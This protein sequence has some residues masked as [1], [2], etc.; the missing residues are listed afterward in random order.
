MRFIP[1]NQLLIRVP[2]MLPFGHRPPSLSTL[3]RMVGDPP[4]PWDTH[5]FPASR[6][7]TCWA[8]M[9]GAFRTRAADWCT[10]DM[11]VVSGISLLSVRP[12]VL[13]I[14]LTDFFS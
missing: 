10:R 9:R 8:R 1:C 14:H 12:A 5:T 6:A 4:L 11:N 7:D 3:S 2:D 13:L